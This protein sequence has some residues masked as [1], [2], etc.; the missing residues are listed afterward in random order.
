MTHTAIDRIVKR[1]AREVAAQIKEGEAARDEPHDL[2]FQA[3]DD[4][5]GELGFPAGRIDQWPTNPGGKILKLLGEVLEYCEAE[6]WLED[7]GG[8]WEGRSGTQVLASQAFFS[9]ENVLWEKL[10]KSNVVS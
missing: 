1:W 7:D 9:L 5:W 2:I 10:R 6:A 8:F 3:V 4:G